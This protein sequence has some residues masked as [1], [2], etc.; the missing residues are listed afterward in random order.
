[1]APAYV[2]ARP[3]YPDFILTFEDPVGSN[4]HYFFNPIG[5]SPKL[6]FIH[7]MEE[8]MNEVPEVYENPYRERMIPMIASCVDFRGKQGKALVEISYKLPLNQLSPSMKQ[9]I[10]TLNLKQGTFFFN[11]DWNESF[12]QIKDRTL[13]R[14]VG[15]NY[16]DTLEMVLIEGDRCFVEP[17]KYH[18][19][20]ELKDNN[21][22]KL[23]RF[24]R[25]VEIPSYSGDQLQMSGI[26]L[27]YSIT[28]SK[29]KG[30]F[31]KNGLYIL[32]NPGQKFRMTQIVHLYFEI[33]NLRLDGEGNSKFVIETSIRSA[34]KKERL[35]ARMFYEMG[36][37]LGIHEQ[38]GI[39]KLSY[40]Y[41]GNREDEFINTALDIHELSPGEYAL[42]ILIR[43]ENKNE[44]T[45]R[46]TNFIVTQD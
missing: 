45:M 26:Q 22:G 5:L 20:F 28:H 27:A 18:F 2:I 11:D 25:D 17:G 32:P 29:N 34:Q 15:K 39:V 36:K 9:N 12:N 4:N 8:F 31:T 14:Q 33:Y 13:R 44:A 10:V 6:K 38:S 3:K 40:G 35:I 21:T 23:A 30:D 42:E 16:S 41:Q 46:S 7:S 43:D 1:M 37:F 19:A 24:Q